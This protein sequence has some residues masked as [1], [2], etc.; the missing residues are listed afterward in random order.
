MHLTSRSAPKRLALAGTVAMQKLCKGNHISSLAHQPFFSLDTQLTLP[1]LCSTLLLLDEEC[2]PLPE[3]QPGSPAFLISHI[4]PFGRSGF[5]ATVQVMSRT[6]GNATYEYMGR[7]VF[8]PKPT[9]VDLRPDIGERLP[10][11]EWCALPTQVNDPCTLA[12]RS[13][14]NMYVSIRCSIS[15]CV[16]L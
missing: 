1:D 2:T 16:A 4:G 9:V 11:G 15:W 5:P 10:Q 12:S 3:T 6:A 7:Y 8:R 13:Y 14:D